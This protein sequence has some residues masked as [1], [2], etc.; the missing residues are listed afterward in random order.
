[1][2]WASGVGRGQ[3]CPFIPVRYRTGEQLFRRGDP[4]EH[5]WYIAEG[6]VELRAAGCPAQRRNPGEFVGL[7]SV[8]C[9]QRAED[10]VV[11]EPARLCAARREGFETWLL[12]DVTR[13]RLALEPVLS[14]D[15]RRATRR[16]LALP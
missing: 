3:F 15:A 10:A 13:L 12:G 4:A 14:Q 16:V 2:G 6:V 11:L 7:D 5:V 8:V 9:P 1:V